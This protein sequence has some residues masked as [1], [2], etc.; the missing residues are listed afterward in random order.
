MVSQRVAHLTSV[1]P[2]FDIRIFHKECKALANAGYEVV[3]VA[4]HGHDNVVN[5]IKIWGVTKHKGRLRRMTRTVWEVCEAA[6]ATNADVYHFHNP[7]LIP[8]G[9]FLKLLGKPVIYDVHEDV[10]KDILCREDI[11]GCLKPPVAMSAAMAEFVGAKLFDK[12]VAA[13]PSIA[14]RF[15]RKKTVVVQNFPVLN[16]LVSP[17]SVSWNE[18]ALA[19][20]YV[21]AIALERGLRQ[22]VEAMGYLSH[23]LRASLKLAGDFSP[24]QHR[25]K[26][27]QLPGWECVDEL[28]FLG[29]SEVAQ[30][31]GRVRAGLVLFHPEPNHVRSQPNKL[32]EYMSASI[33]V[34]VSD[35]S[36]WRRV[37]ETNN[38]G[39]LVD[40]L[41]PRAIAGA[42]E[43]LLTHPN[44]AEAMGQRGRDAVEKYFNWDTEQA[45][46]LQLY[47][48]LTGETNVR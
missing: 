25:D 20:A 30:L 16:E 42:I 27:T 48:S 29:R 46:L 6:I 7:E 40:P 43:Y 11:A 4:C 10:P 23:R 22:M 18:R 41:D 1:H 24:L 14:Q 19:V 33:P 45:K 5:G 21:G 35:F 38:C 8:V 26:V 39:L 2:P 37:I 3:L 36:L 44:E 15:P 9:M 12:I 13:T 47:E 17:V 32:F 31:L 28:G 34:I